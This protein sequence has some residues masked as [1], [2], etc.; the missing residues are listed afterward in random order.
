M[1]HAFKFCVLVISAALGMGDRALAQCFVCSDGN[2]NT[3]VGTSAL[4]ANTS[5]GNNTAVGFDSLAASTTGSGNTAVGFDSL[6]ANTSG[7]YNTAIGYQAFTA[8]TTGG[9]STAIG[10]YALQVNTT[11]G[12]NTA[13]GAYSLPDNVSGTANTAFGYGVLRSNTIGNNNIAFGYLALYSDATGSNNIAI[14][15]QAAYLVTGSNTIE[16]GTQ[17]AGGDNSVI[18]IGTPGT[19]K[20]TY[21][22]G[23]SGSQVT[24][25]AVYVTSSGQLG[26]LASSERYKTAITP[27]G[28]DTEKLKHLRPVSFHLKADP[29][30]AVQYGLIAEEVAKIYPELVI[31]D[32]AGKIQGVRYEELAPMLLNEMQRQEH[33]IATQDEEIREL[34]QQQEQMQATLLELQS[35]DRLVAQR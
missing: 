15:N 19:Q 11:G 34:K 16:I 22:A 5:G 2:R 3:L 14:G 13:F 10:T 1:S 9:Y 27:I 35:K 4:G 26:V 20:A 6:A 29:N 8:N 30:G 17:G 23:I 7:S 21:V 28:A 12:Y 25:S 32:D 31:R 18:R 24:G 33:R